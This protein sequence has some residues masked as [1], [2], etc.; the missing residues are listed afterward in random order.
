MH[1]YTPYTYLI[2]WSHFNKWYYGVRYAKGCHPKDL[3][4]TYFTSSKHV[5][6]FR[7]HYGDPDI[8]QIRKTFS[9]RSE[10]LAWEEK[11]LKKMNV[12][13]ESKWIN[14]TYNR[15]FPP[16]DELP[17]EVQKRRSELISESSKN[18]K[19]PTGRV[20]SKETREK[21]KNIQ[22]TVWKSYNDEEYEK[23]KERQRIGQ[24]KVSQ[25]VRKKQFERRKETLNCKL[26]IKCPHC[27]KTSK[28]GGASAMSRHHFDNCKKIDQKLIEKTKLIE[29]LK[30]EISNIKYLKDNQEIKTGCYLKTRE[31]KTQRKEIKQIK[32]Y[33]KK[34]KITLGKSWYQ[35]STNWL[36]EVLH[37]L[38]IFDDKIID[39]EKVH[40]YYR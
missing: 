31:I 29:D 34:Y 20:V 17:I 8:I 39:L 2:G 18:R 3:W 33:L 27:G 36:K 4:I 14:V 24:K 23:R 19:Y 28:P 5:K 6:Q 40:T 11:V 35:K 30:N 7:E 21:L 26:D 1:I 12:A 38:R 10:A 16:I 15:G 9:N 22:A 25:S 13:N 37:I 32:T